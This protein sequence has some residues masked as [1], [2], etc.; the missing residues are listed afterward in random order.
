MHRRKGPVG[1]TSLIT[2][3]TATGRKHRIGRLEK[4][5][6]GIEL[7]E[8]KAIHTLFKSFI[9]TIIDNLI[10]KCIPKLDRCWDETPG[11]FVMY[12]IDSQTK[13]DPSGSRSV[14]KHVLVVREQAN[15]HTIAS[16]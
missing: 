12:Y 2:E 5:L 3:G 10:G 8:K 14:L 9:F 16:S 13:N 4:N 11:K 15:D 6:G 1:G 7:R